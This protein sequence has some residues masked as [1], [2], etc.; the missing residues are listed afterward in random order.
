MREEN[1][2]V[3]KGKVSPVRITLRMYDLRIVKNGYQEID[4]SYEKKDSFHVTCLARIL[5]I[6]REQNAVSSQYFGF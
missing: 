6:Q 5:S 2:W 4:E 3:V 1:V